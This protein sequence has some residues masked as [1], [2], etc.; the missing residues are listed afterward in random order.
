MVVCD[1]HM[2]RIIETLPTHKN[3]GEAA[4]VCV[5]CGQKEKKSSS[6]VEILACI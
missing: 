1:W 2:R 5:W 3:N 4:N 6:S